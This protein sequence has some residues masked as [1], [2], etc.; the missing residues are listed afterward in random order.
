MPFQVGL[1]ICI[2]GACL[3]NQMIMQ[4]FTW[5]YEEVMYEM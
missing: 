4:I 2:F 5:K 1:A 3:A